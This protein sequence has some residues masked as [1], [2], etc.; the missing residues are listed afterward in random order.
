MSDK[1]PVR[2]SYDPYRWLAASVLLSAVKAH[3]VWSTPRAAAYRLRR[4]QGQETE[5]RMSEAWRAIAAE[6]ED[7]GEILRRDT[8]W[9]QILDIEPEITAQLLER[10]QSNLLGLVGGRIGRMAEIRRSH[11]RKGAADKPTAT[12]TDTGSTICASP[13]SGPVQGSD[14]ILEPFS[15]SYEA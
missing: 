11:R 15:Q 6:P 8:M 13:E 4:A 5:A 3:V 14:R 1:S 2:L 12:K 9:H 10:G 7:P